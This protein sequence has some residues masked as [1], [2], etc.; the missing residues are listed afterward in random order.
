MGA[1]DE[2]DSKERDNKERWDKMETRV[3]TVPKVETHQRGSTTDFRQMD[4]KATDAD[5]RI[6]D[7]TRGASGKTEQRN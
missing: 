6:D 4:R 1:V 7:P 2:A 5:Q 3:A